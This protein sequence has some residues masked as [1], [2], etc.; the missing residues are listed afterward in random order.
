MKIV[1]TKLNEEILVD[2]E[3]YEKVMK[4]NW[5]LNPQGYPCRYTGKQCLFLHHLIIEPYPGQVID[6]ANG[7]K[8]D[9]RRCNLRACTSSQNCAN[10]KL[11]KS[12]TSGFRGIVRDGSKWRGVAT[13]KGKK[14]NL[15]T[16]LTKE[17]AAKAFE[18]YKKKV[19]GEFAK[20]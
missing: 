4:F 9:N 18:N 8:R 5:V 12:N 2:D 14:I 19:F 6:H 11:Y 3:D 1:L 16:F 7:S 20:I 17:D 15:G 13:V 10:S